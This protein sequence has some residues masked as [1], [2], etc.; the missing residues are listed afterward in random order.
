LAL[1]TSLVITFLLA[2]SAC[3]GVEHCK[4]GDARC[5]GGACEKDACDYDLVCVVRPAGERLCGRPLDEDD[6][7]DFGSAGKGKGE[8]AEDLGPPC[9]CEQPELCSLDTNSCVNYCEVP[10]ALP[11]SEPVPEVIFCEQFE[12]EA[13]LSFEEICKRLCRLSCQ[14]WEQFCGFKCD[15]D[16]C[17]APDV[18]DACEASCPEADGDPELCLTRACNAVR[19]QGCANVICPD[20]NEPADCT[21]VV[22]KNTCG[23]NSSP[24]WSGDGVC[25]DGELLSATYAD[26]AWGTDCTDCGPRRGK[27][28]EP[29]PQGGVCA[30]NTGCAG[31]QQDLKTNAAWCVSLDD[32][33]KGLSRCVPDCSRGRTCP[34]GYECVAVLDDMDERIEQD[35]L[36]G[37]ACIPLVCD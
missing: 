20:T 21:G 7:Y 35:D 2:A 6:E 10:D 23:G 24:E 3:S 29:E 26:C 33:A 12:D 32:V 16:D 9:E 22:C 27:P 1:T 13:P 11:G 30:F 4:D 5:I 28:P 36:V 37:Q 31:Y 25:D 14:R 15:E 19:D 34:S 17:D 18:L 8:K